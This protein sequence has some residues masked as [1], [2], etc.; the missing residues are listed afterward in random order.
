[1][2]ASPEQAKGKCLLL[3]L[4]CDCGLLFGLCTVWACFNGNTN[5]LW[6]VWFVYL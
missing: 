2:V 1:M 4:V 6:I 5:L 3:L